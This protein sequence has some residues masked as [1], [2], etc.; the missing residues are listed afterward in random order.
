MGPSGFVSPE[1]AIPEINRLLAAKDW[2]GL[3]GH[4]D[5]TGTTVAP[6]ELESGAFF[7]ALPDG[8]FRHPGW[9]RGPLRPF[10]PGFRYASHE[11][12]GDEAVVTVSIE[13]DEG[14][15]MVQQGCARFRMRR[16]AGA[17]KLRPEPAD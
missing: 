8:G 17:W 11:E 16:V 12:D 2:V 1:S 4:Y 14:G 7:V 15:G 13:I 10:P 9:P 5:L 6:A 3:T